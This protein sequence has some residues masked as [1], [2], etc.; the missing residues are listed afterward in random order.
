MQVWSLEVSSLYARMDLRMG[1]KREI[2]ARN[3]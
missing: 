2:L 1:L 3:G